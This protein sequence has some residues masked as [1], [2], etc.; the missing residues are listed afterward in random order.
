M[1]RGVRARLTATIVA[2]VVV[3]AAV[4]GLAASAFVDAR[5][6]QQT[7]D[8]ARDQARFDLSVL[9]PSRLPDPPSEEDLRSLAAD[10]QFRNLPTIIVAAG[11]EPFLST[12]QLG[13]V[14]D[15]IPRDVRTLVEQ[16]QIAYSWQTVGGEPSLVIGGRSGGTGP[17]IYFIRDVAPIQ[18]AIDQLRQQDPDA[19]SVIVLDYMMPRCS[20]PQFRQKQ[21]ADPQIADVPVILVSAV[22][23]LSSRAALLKPF[24]MLQKPI[25]PDELTAA[26]R[27]AC[28]AYRGRQS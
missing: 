25:N 28:S 20:G 13:G 3:T 21:L 24:A 9:A 5:L 27:E 14:L 2:L 23:D 10:F 16:G 8:E 12:A 11:R 7:L 19:P 18:Q 1:I 22:S 6:H 26:V 17:E 4:L 15:T